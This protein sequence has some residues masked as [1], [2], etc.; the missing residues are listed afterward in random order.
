M[1]P[2]PSKT[3]P[4]ILGN[5]ENPYMNIPTPHF[6]LFSQANRENERD[7]WSFVLKAADGSAI[8]KVADAEPDAHGER[9][10]LLAVVRGLEALEQPS[11]VTLV[12]PSRY[13]KRG[14]SYGLPEW[15]RN[16][17]KWEHFGEMVPVK[18]RDLW[19]RLDRALKIHRI[20]G[21]HFRV[22]AAHAGE[23]PIE[24]ARHGATPPDRP[25]ADGWKPAIDGFLIRCRAWLSELFERFWLSCA[26]LGTS[27]L[28]YPWLE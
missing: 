13:V 19:Q 11:R 27:L 25:T 5:G 3:V 18:N 10:E 6:F 15:G 26:Q 16:G 12:T 28:P 4:S 20:Q 21:A 7:E 2:G 9:L 22:D 14:I 17:W 8:L 24:A 1:L 23:A